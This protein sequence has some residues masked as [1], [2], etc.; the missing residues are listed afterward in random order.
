MIEEETAL[1]LQHIN[2]KL[3]LKDSGVDLDAVIPVF[4]EWIQQQVTPE[5]LL[6]VASYAHVKNGP[7]ILLIGHE[8]DY[9]LDLADGR[10]GLRYN[11]KAPFP[12]D[13]Q[14][15]LEQA[16]RAALEALQRLEADPR[17]A[18]AFQFD[19]RH[20]DLFINDRL[21]APNT[22]STREA[23]DPIVR[24]LLSRL[25]GDESVSVEYEAD[26]RKL[27]GARIE[28]EREIAVSELLNNL[29]VH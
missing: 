15:R 22:D 23:A 27:F 6:D 10:P 25:L 1:E 14:A 7:G 19:G 12:G 16:A 9:S 26:P 3:Q 13:N 4:H 29:L 2:V 28:F 21:L 17:T 18:D 11:R 5:L 24:T 20:L 8:A